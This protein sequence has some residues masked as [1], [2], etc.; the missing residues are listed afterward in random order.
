M[1][2]LCKITFL[3]SQLKLKRFKIKFTQ[4]PDY[5]IRYTTYTY[6]VELISVSIST[7][8]NILKMLTKFHLDRKTI[9]SSLVLKHQIGRN[10]I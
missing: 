5:L 4:Y 9:T 10:Y 1:S 3:L 8:F 6:I 7:K 2:I